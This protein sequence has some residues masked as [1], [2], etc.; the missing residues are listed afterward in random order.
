[1]PPILSPSAGPGVHAACQPGR[2]VA[3]S[4]WDPALPRERAAARI[5]KALAE[6]P[7]LGEGRPIRAP[8]ADLPKVDG[9]PVPESG[10]GEP[11]HGRR[12]TAGVPG[13]SPGQARWT[14]RRSGTGGGAPGPARGGPAHRGGDDPVPQGSSRSGARRRREQMR[15]G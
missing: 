11:R 14:R 2:A 6:V 12:G 4:R 7:A 10:R 3:V 15:G 8:R 5:E 13:A 9:Q 1:M